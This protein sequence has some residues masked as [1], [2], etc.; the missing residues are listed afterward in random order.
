MVYV[1]PT[2]NF[3]WNGAPNPPLTPVTVIEPLDPPKHDGCANDTVAT[4][5]AGVR[6]GVGVEVGCAVGVVVG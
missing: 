4:I 2:F 6:V 5:A 1:P 3:V